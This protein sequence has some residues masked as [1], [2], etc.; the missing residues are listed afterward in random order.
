MV[1]VTSVLEVY[2]K[3]VSDPLKSKMAVGWWANSLLVTPLPIRCYGQ[4][5]L[6]L[7]DVIA[8]VKNITLLFFSSSSRPSWGIYFNTIWIPINCGKKTILL[9]N[10]GKVTIY[11]MYLC[12]LPIRDSPI[13]FQVITTCQLHTSNSVFLWSESKIIRDGWHGQLGPEGTVGYRWEINSI[14]FGATLAC[15]Q[16][17]SS[18]S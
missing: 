3:H 11:S 13:M 15:V 4:N 18:L 8:L 1:T 6:F 14:M 2:L 16:S 5:F 10:D 9:V 17:N 12:I 7:E